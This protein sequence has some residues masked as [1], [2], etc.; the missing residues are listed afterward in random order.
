MPAE[1]LREP[2]AVKLSMP[3]EEP[4]V[5]EIGDLPNPRLAA[6]LAEGLAACVH[7][8]GSLG[9]RTTFNSFLFTMRRMVRELAENGFDGPAEEL[10]R[11]VLGAFW[12]RSN[13]LVEYRT[14]TILRALDQRRQ[15]LDEPVRQ[16]VFGINYKR[17]VSN[18]PLKPYAPAE[19]NRVIDLCKQEVRRLRTR[20]EAM[21]KLAETGQEPAVGGW[22]IANAAWLLRRIGPVKAAVVAEHMGMTRSAFMTRFRGIHS[23]RKALFPSHDQ[24]V[25]YV[26]LLTAWTGIVPDGLTGMQVSGIS[27]IG[28]EATLLSYTKGRTADESLVLSARASRL[29]ERWQS[30]VSLL[31]ELAPDHLDDHFWLVTMQGHQVAP[32]TFADYVLRAWV[33]DHDLRSEAGEPLWIDRRRLRTT[34]IAQ[35]GQR[36]WSPRATIDP[37]HSPQVEGDHYLTAA[38]PAQKAVVDEIARDA[39]ADLLRR[40]SAPVI[41]DATDVAT[42]LPEE[43]RRMGLEA[44]ALAELLSGERDVFT[45]ACGDQLAGLHGPRGKP[46]P[47]RPWVCLLCPLALFAPRHL[48][49]LLR[50]KGYFARQFREMPRDQFAATLAPYAR[51]L[52]AEILPR[53]A[54]AA[55]TAAQSEVRDEDAELP[56]RA[57]EFTS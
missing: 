30:H 48:P 33:K 25:N 21:L 14:R 32:A 50:L 29:L 35:R 36:Q 56:L 1:V 15:V 51:R 40:A 18:G 2:L 31:R 26:L 10:T 39:Q 55:V 13:Y 3:D 7:P 43:V 9:K 16:L 38:T 22:S 5:V 52:S 27:W 4:C 8:H 19:W 53:F 37:N 12:L 20:H 41:V 24:A 28:K 54:A 45:A 34:F 44:G 47:A 49:N 46:C 6:D 42:R 17:P 57:E 23:V 11:A